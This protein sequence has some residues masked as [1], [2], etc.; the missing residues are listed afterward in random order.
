MLSNSGLPGSKGLSQATPGCQTS[1]QEHSGQPCLSQPDD[2]VR[3]KKLSLS[4]C[5]MFIPEESQVA[6]QTLQ[7]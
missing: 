5:K 1:A 7:P 4:I 2:K 3:S 6:I